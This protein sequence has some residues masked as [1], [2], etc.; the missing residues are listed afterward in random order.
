MSK[1][2][3]FEQALIHRDG[4]SKAEARRQR[5]E[6]RESLYDILDNGGS[7]DDVEDMLAGDY[8]LEMDYI[9]DILF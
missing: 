4:V 9:F 1:T 8:G 3:E 7:Y 6:A 5:N 2:T